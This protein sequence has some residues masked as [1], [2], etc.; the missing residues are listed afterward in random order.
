[1]CLSDKAI[2]MSGLDGSGALHTVLS[3]KGGLVGTP[4][5]VAGGGELAGLN[6]QFEG[7]KMREMLPLHAH[8]SHGF[9]NLSP[10]LRIPSVLHTAAPYGMPELG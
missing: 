1:M 4:Q 8:A 10:A 5:E 6:R 3:R 9:V 7:A 2:R